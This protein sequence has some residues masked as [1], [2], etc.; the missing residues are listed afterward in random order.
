VWFVCC[1]VA[2]FTECTT[3]WFAQKVIERPFSLQND[4]RTPSAL[5]KFFVLRQLSFT[6]MSTQQSDSLLSFSRDRVIMPINPYSSVCLFKWHF[7]TV[8]I[9]G[10]TKRVKKYWKRK[11]PRTIGQDCSS[12]PLHIIECVF[13][14]NIIFPYSK[15]ICGDLIWS[16]YSTIT[17]LRTGHMFARQIRDSLKKLSVELILLRFPLVFCYRTRFGAV[18][19]SAIPISSTLTDSKVCCDAVW[20]ESTVQSDVALTLFDISSLVAVCAAHE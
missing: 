3:V 8:F 12:Y 16:N 7:V 2:V 9:E 6:K 10:L 11:A 20:F 14:E 13:R 4:S 1:F 15:E 19:D 17:V 5:L 18:H